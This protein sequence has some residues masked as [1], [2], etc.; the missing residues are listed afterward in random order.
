MST[1]PG[2]PANAVTRVVTDYAPEARS[3]GV[4]IAREVWL[5]LAGF[6]TPVYAGGDLDPGN[7]FSGTTEPMQN[8]KGLNNPAATSSVIRD[9]DYA[10][11]ES[12]VTA[13]PTGRPEVRIFADRL[14]RRRA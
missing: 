14:R 13:G 10:T 2:G 9:G 6:L 3:P 11:I 12:A 8:F 5:R 4:S 1:L 7:R